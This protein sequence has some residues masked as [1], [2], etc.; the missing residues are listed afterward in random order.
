MEKL[1]FNIADITLKIDVLDILKRSGALNG[2]NE[3]EAANIIAKDYAILATQRDI[4]NNAIMMHP[5]NFSNPQITV[6]APVLYYWLIARKE[7]VYDFYFDEKDVKKNVATDKSKFKM[8]VPIIADHE[9][10][11]H[12]YDY[13][14]M[15]SKTYFDKSQRF[16]YKGGNIYIP[17]GVIEGVNHM[18]V[19]LCSN[20]IVFNQNNKPINLTESPNTLQSGDDLCVLMLPRL[21]MNYY[22][23][24]KG[25][26][27]QTY[28]SEYDKHKIE[29]GCRVKINDISYKYDKGDYLQEV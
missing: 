13:K 7:R 23:R 21:Y 5:L 25:N 6:F 28:F 8:S 9:A 16:W 26:V 15:M 20:E 4:Q 22:V 2:L 29:N 11:E 10:F 27:Y 19:T 3:T 18:G 12:D 1:L 14:E 17:Y 24:Y